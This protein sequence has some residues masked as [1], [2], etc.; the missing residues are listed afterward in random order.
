MIAGRISPKRTC[1]SDEAVASGFA[2]RG[3][4]LPGQGSCGVPGEIDHGGVDG[5]DTPSHRERGSNLV[6]GD[7]T[8]S[9]VT[10]LAI[11][12]AE[13]VKPTTHGDHFSQTLDITLTLVVIEDVEEPAVEHGLE[14]VPKIN[15]AKGIS[16][17]E[18]C[19]DS[20]FGCLR[21]G[22]VDGLRRQVDPHC[23]VAE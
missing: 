13:H 15:E 9:P 20:T 7:P 14:L 6:L 19:P 11:A 5:F 21:L 8:W 23:V 1:G 18:A 22:Q 4:D 12:E 10:R 17:D 16:D 3:S 2:A